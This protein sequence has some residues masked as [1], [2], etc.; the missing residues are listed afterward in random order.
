MYIIIIFSFCYVKKIKEIETILSRFLCNPGARAAHLEGFKSM[1]PL[2][3]A[4]EVFG[5][6]SLCSFE[7]LPT[8]RAVIR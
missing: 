4:A 5:V 6:C 7:A 3:R 8:P 2:A 1:S